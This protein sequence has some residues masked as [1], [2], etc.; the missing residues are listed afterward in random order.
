MSSSPTHAVQRVAGDALGRL[1]ARSA[2]LLLR[3]PRVQQKALLLATLIGLSANASAITPANS[4]INNIA[5]ANY[6]VGVVNF[7]RT[8]SKLVNTTSCFVAD[9]KVDLLQQIPAARAANAPN[10]VTEN[11][12]PGQFAM[13]SAVGAFTP[14]NNPTLLNNTSST[15]LPTP[16]L[17]SK[18]NDALGNPISAYSRNEPIFVRVVSYDGNLNGA[19]QDTITISVATTI[20]G[21]KE[22]IKLTETGVSTGVFVG[23]IPTTFAVGTPAILY[24]GKINIAAHNETISAAYD[25]TDCAAGTVASSSSG[26]IDPYGVVFDSTSGVPVN[27]AVLRMV[28]AGG[29][30]VTVFCDDGVTPLVQPITSGSPTNCDAIVIPGGF[31]FPQLP[32][33]SY[34]I[35]IAPPSGYVNSTKPVASLPVTIGTTPPAAPVIE[36]N[37]ITGGSYGGLFT[38]WGPALKLD[39]PLDANATAL[40]IVKA[41][42]RTTAVTGDFVPYTVTVTSTAATVTGQILDTPPV[43]LIYKPGSATLNGVAIADPVIASNG[44]FTISLTNAVNP[45]VIAYQLEVTSAAVVGAASNV[46]AEVGNLTNTSTASVTVSVPVL[47]IDKIAEKAVASTGDFVPYT[48]NIKSTGSIIS[49]LIADHPPVGFRYQKGSARLN[50]VAMADPV[51]AA[52]ASVLTFNLANV[53]SPAIIRYVLEITPAAHLGSA[54]NTAA[55][56]GG[57]T[58]NTAHAT[59][60]VREDLFRNKTILIGRVIDGSCDDQVENDDKGLANARVVMEDGTYALTDKEGRWHVDNVRAGTHV[61]QLDLDSLPKDYEVASWCVVASRF[62][63]AEKASGRFAHLTN[64]QHPHARRLNDCLISGGERD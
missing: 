46:A 6:S 19:V 30:D 23:A 43:G 64:T 36:S 63:C 62:S 32:A 52:D 58:S 48:L 55:A 38:L 27:G 12:Q 39:L 17:L 18:L 16:L 34:K 8:G 53:P 61:V 50:G 11:V 20:G 31:R 21:D 28:D 37:L 42:V 41:S 40:T 9:I 33:G 5:T 45:S 54:E 3:T 56:T 13:G 7:T 47:T 51:I 15:A 60:V 29:T 1:V 24:D 14:L 49:A 10:A 2:R 35:V 57:A 22:T 44:S 4:P 59:V 26:L 25:H